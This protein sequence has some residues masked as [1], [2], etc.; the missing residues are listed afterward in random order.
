MSIRVLTDNTIVLDRADTFPSG[1]INTDP[2]GALMQIGL[3]IGA[4]GG[5]AHHCH[6]RHTA[7]DNHPDIRDTFIAIVLENRI[8]IDQRF[9]HGAIVATAETV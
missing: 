3:A 8:K 4:A 9:N 5:A 6:H 1:Y 7:K 2:Y